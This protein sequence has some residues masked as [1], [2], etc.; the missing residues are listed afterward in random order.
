M[1]RTSNFTEMPK[2]FNINDIVMWEE[3]AQNLHL[4]LLSVILVLVMFV[5]LFIVA[6]VRILCHPGTCPQ[7][8]HQYGVCCIYYSHKDSFYIGSIEWTSL[9]FGRTLIPCI[10]SFRFTVSTSLILVT[11][12]LSPYWVCTRSMVLCGLFFFLDRYKCWQS[13]WNNRVVF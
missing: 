4:S 6:I 11:I 2:T 8:H 3:G 10:C 5:C 9:G 12:F 13:S 1:D 7:P